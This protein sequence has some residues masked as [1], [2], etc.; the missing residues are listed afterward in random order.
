M[1]LCTAPAKVV[2]TQL[3]VGTRPRDVDPLV[4][5]RQCCS[6]GAIPVRPAAYRLRGSDFGFVTTFGAGVV[7]CVRRLEARGWRM[8]DFKGR[9]FGGEIALWAVRW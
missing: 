1:L 3:S 6:G 5:P 2:W 7:N 8:S 4:A 9:D